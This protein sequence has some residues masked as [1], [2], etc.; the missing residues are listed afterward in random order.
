MILGAS[1]IALALIAGAFTFGGAAVT[2]LVTW[3]IFREGNA[4]DIEKS[5][6]SEV[7]QA[8]SELNKET[9]DR[10]ARLETKVEELTKKVDALQREVLQLTEELGRQHL[11]AGENEMLKAANERLLLELQALRKP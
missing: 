9:N 7:W 3:L 8:R 4:G 11:L 6:A 1:T 5:P 2:A 10:N